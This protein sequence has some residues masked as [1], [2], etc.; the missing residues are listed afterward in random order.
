MANQCYI[1]GSTQNY[2]KRKKKITWIKSRGNKLK[3]NNK[4]Y[5]LTPWSRVV[6]KKP[7]SKL[8]S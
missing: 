2:S 4:D 6:I 5:L 8:L 7:T 1:V 3:L